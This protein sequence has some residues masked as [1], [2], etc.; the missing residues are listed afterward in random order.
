LCE[1]SKREEVCANHGCARCDHQRDHSAVAECDEHSRPPMNIRG[2]GIKLFAIAYPC[3]PSARLRSRE[4][5][6]YDSI[7]P[8]TSACSSGFDGAS[9]A[10]SYCCSRSVLTCRS[11]VLRLRANGDPDREQAVVHRCTVAWAKAMVGRVS[12]YLTCDDHAGCM[13]GSFENVGWDRQPV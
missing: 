1:P 3:V 11:L 9:R 6:E 12:E 8:S 10:A 2:S 13:I 7:T 5:A 4:H